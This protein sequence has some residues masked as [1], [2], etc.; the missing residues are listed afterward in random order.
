MMQ[1]EYMGWSLAILMSL[2]VHGMMFMQS[3]ARVGVEN[4]TA[5]QAPLITR[6]SFNQAAEKPVLDEPVLKKEQPPKPVEVAKPK[7]VDVIKK[8]E[9]ARP[10]EEIQPVRQVLAPT[11][12][13]GQQVAQNSDGLLKQ[14][15]QQYLH[16]LLSHIESFKYYPRAARRRSMEGS[17]SISFTLRGDGFYDQLVMDG[18]HAVLVRAAEQ[19]LESATPLPTPPDDIGL[20]NEIEFTMVYS[21]T[22]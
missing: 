1:S 8:I 9:R 12:T 11:Q 2:F 10:V 17:V 20:S 13:R 19:A 5:F 4:T 14:K 3:G 15:R 16:K 7:P 21:I 22:G 6:L 18:K